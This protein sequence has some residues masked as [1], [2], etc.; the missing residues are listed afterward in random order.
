MLLIERLK[1]TSF[2]DAEQV[3]V[4][5][6]IDHPEGLQDMTTQKIADLTHTNPTSLIR[7]AKKMGFTGWLDL[8]E[9]YLEEWQYLNSHFTAIDANL[10]YE[11]TDHLISIA[12]KI[13]TLQ[14]NTLQDT[15][16]LIDSK[17]LEH[18]QKLLLN[19]DEIKVFA[20]K[21]NALIAQDFVTKMRRINKKITISSTYDY[22]TYEAFNSG[23]RTC[24]LIIS[25][26]GEDDSFIKCMDILKKQG[27]ST[28]SLTSIGDNPIATNSDC[29]LKITTR[30]KLY[31]KIGNFTSTTSV[32]YLLNLL[33]SIVFTAD[34]EMNLNHLIQIGRS[35]DTRKTNIDIIKEQS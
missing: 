27:A 32:I 24:A 12:H 14:Q 2:S 33:Y 34:Y 10:P 29:S 20:S 3:L 17:D 28:I 5:Y 7:V 1:H 9:A 22:S 25:Y 21:T 35:T 13:N 26:T 11:Q 19:A 30:E 31:S 6:L 15:L 18:A 16:S 8:K 23:N 4:S